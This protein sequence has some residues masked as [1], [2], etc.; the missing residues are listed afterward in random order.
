MNTTNVKQS[1]YFMDDPREAGR[2]DAKVNTDEFIE[3]FI[4]PYL[5]E[6]TTAKMVDIGCGAGAITSA[7]A[8]K[9]TN[10]SIKGVDLSADRLANA[11]EKCAYIGN[12]EFV[13]GSIYEIPLKDNSADF[14]YTRFL[15]EYLKDPVSGIKE[16]HRVCKKNGLVML[17]D[18]DGQLLF[19]YPETIENLDKVLNGLSKTGFDPMIGRKLL[20]YGLLAGFELEHIDIRPYHFIVGK[21]DEKNDHLWDLKMEIA[22]PK[23]E[24]ILGSMEK[25]KKFKDDFMAFLRDPQTMMYSNLCTIYLKK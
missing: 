9:F 21:I 16:M 23:F 18:L 20:H 8:K 14:L 25:A 10:A 15:L 24:D 3:N 7:L 1:K 22:L 13:Q 11:R 19:H 12:A 4:L 17:Q 2:L 6:E 5:K